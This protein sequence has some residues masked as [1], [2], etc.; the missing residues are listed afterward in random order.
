MFKH[1]PPRFIL[2]TA[3]NR[4]GDSLMLAKHAGQAR[5]LPLD[6]GAMELHSDGNMVL[7]RF[8]GGGEI[9]VLGGAGDCEMELKI[10]VFAM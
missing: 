9:I 3:G 1:Q 10:C 4:S 5:S 7:Q 8:H 2:V 6:R